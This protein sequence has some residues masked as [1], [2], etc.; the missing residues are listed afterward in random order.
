MKPQRIILIRHGESEGNINKEIYTQ[1][2][3]YALYLTNKGIAKDRIITDG[4]GA[5][6]PIASNATLEGRKANQRVEFLLVKGD[7]LTT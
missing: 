1:K 4:K 3:D 6:N 5:S 2:P 7:I